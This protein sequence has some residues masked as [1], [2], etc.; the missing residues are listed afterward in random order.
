MG[1]K[2]NDTDKKRQLLSEGPGPTIILF[3]AV[4][5]GLIITAAFG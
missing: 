2:Q 1:L 4:V 5:A 3:I